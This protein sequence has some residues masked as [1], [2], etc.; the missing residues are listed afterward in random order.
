[1]FLIRDKYRKKAIIARGKVNNR[2]FIT[3]FY[4]ER[5]VGF[6]GLVQQFGL[7]LTSAKSSLSMQ[8]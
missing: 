2:Q 8:S 7:I 3:R 5:F 4:Q 1:M 6:N